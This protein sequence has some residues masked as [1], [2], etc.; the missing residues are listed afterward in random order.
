[1]KCL[2]PN[3]GSTSFKYRLLDMPGESILAEGR[4][5]RIGQ[6]GSDCPDYPSAIAKCIAAISGEGKA[7]A[8]LAEGR[9]A[10]AVVERARA[11]QHILAGQ[12]S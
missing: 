11:A 6:P 8:S 9:D 7:L 10:M 4:V 2:I 3:I 12:A 5:E 1:M